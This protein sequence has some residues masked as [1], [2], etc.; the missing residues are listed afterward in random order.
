MGAELADSTRLVHE[1]LCHFVLSCGGVGIFALDSGLTTKATS[2]EWSSVTLLPPL[3][4]YTLPPLSV[5]SLS[6]V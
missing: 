3:V 4:A 6:C 2:S 5:Q 1:A